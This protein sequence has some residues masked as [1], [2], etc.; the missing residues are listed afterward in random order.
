MFS[1]YLKR[2]RL[3]WGKKSAD[4]YGRT[5]WQKLMGS[6]VKDETSIEIRDVK[7]EPGEEAPAKPQKMVCNP[8]NAKISAIVSIGYEGEYKGLDFKIEAIEVY[9]D[10]VGTKN[11]SHADYILRNDD[12]KLRL[13]VYKKPTGDL[14]CELYKD[15]DEMGWDQ[16][17]W[18]VL[19]HDSHE[20]E[21]NEDDNG[22]RLDT[23]N[24]YWRVNGA[25]D[26]YQA[27][28]QVLKDV[29]GDGK[30]SDK[31]VSNV[32]VNYWDYSRETDVNGVFNLEFMLV[33]MNSD[34]KYFN[35][36]RGKEIKAFQLTVI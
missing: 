8:L 20:F 5:L 17:F 31:E 2:L 24:V 15:Y 4:G 9:T 35:L 19:N 32:E 10:H 21:V 28:K 11:F 3:S 12:K 29:D 36:Y 27:T 16:G 13:R 18:D 7:P 1:T 26:P 6:N 34:T 30:V 23:P 33:E 14:K 25:V 22:N